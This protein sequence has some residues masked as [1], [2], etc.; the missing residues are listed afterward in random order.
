MGLVPRDGIKTMQAL[1]DRG[2]RSQASR[3][4]PRRAPPRRAPPRIGFPRPPRAARRR[5]TVVVLHSPAD[6]E[7][8]TNQN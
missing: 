6:L 8:R 7:H 3:A 4:P 1:M 2:L 5:T